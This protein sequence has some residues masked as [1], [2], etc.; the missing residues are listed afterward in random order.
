M[1]VSEL[2]TPRFLSGGGKMGALVR[3]K[4]WSETPL[5]SP[6]TWPQSL[7]TTVSLLLNSQFPMFVW[8]GPELTA[9]YNDS[10]IP[11]AGEKHPKLL[12]QSGREAWAEIWPDLGPL[13]ES[14]FAGVSTWS[15]DQLLVM[16][17]YG[18]DEETYFTFS[19]SPV[20][21]EQGVVSGLF[22]ACIET[23][24][25]VLA[26][27]RIAESE[28]N[29]RNTILQAPVAMC[30]L[31]GSEFRVEIANERM[32]HLWGRGAEQMAGRPIF[33]GIPESRNQGLEEI[34]LGVYTTGE[35]FVAYERPV[36]LPRDGK[37]AMVYINFVYES[38][39]EGDGTISGVLA[40]A[41]DVTEQVLSRKRVEASEQRVRALVESA[42]FPIGVYE[43]RE[44]RIVLANQAIMDGWG[45][46]NDVVGK[47]YADLLPELGSQAVFQQLD[48]VYTTGV[49]FHARNQRLDLMVGERTR[50]YYFNYSFTPLLDTEGKVYGVMNTAADVTDLNLAKQQVEQSERNFRDMILQ[51]PVAM[52]ILLGPAHVIDIAND[53]MITLW[54]KPRESVMQKPVFDALPDA[55]EQGLEKIISDVYHT[56]VVFHGNELPVELVRNGVRETVY[57]NFVYQPYLD[58]DGTVL[59]V[60]AISVDMT[61]QVIARRQ[62][63]EIVVQRTRELAAANEALTKSNQELKR[64]NTNLEEFA[65]AA[66]HD[67]KEPIRKIHFFADRLKNELKEQ[68]TPQ[69][70]SLFLRLEGASKRMGALID[71]LL[72]YSQATRGA[73]EQEVTDLNIRLANVL[74]DLELEIEQ[75]GAVIQADPLPVIM[76]NGRQFQQLF[77]N[78]VSNALKYSRPDTAPL[79]SIS[80][81][82]VSGSEVLEQMPAADPKSHFH[83]IEVADNGIGF[84]Q[85]DAER[86]FNVFTRLHGN[87]EF[88]GTG[89]GLSIARKVV[90]NHGGFIWAE[91]APGEGSVFFILLPEHG[92]PAPARIEEPH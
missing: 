36:L 62:I 5:G 48:D 7:R 35:P 90:D 32:Y 70:Q 2:Q 8:W 21:N 55:R 22:C 9:I 84:E 42:P 13:V 24:E 60:L 85:K 6:E 92:T 29:L 57:Q 88:R 73:A 27:R 43:G 14:V 52:C 86:I 74:H 72:S 26:A 89:V 53:M 45:K 3:Q 30:I 44:M 65:Y 49:P 68:L 18:Y 54:G 75:K 10:Y 41:Y 33:D 69:Q 83:L 31:R 77:Q 91:S 50:S 4:N 51:A 16:N 37:A 76:G 56:G 81:R 64:S 58:A 82:L 79:V 71:D 1:N 38:F 46:G 12:G 25:Q 40:V 67:M 19:Y 80:Y 87:S 63:E 20:L 61:Q 39:R 78:L 23:T 15:V 17:R 66:S 47:R 28:R 59:G 11:I 34:L